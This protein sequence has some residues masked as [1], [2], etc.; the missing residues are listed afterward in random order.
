MGRKSKELSEDRK[1]ISTRT[2]DRSHFL[3]FANT[4]EAALY[5]SIT[6]TKARPLGRKILYGILVFSTN[7]ADRQDITGEK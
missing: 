6:T 5:H 3:I 7:I 4:Y 2:T 1:P